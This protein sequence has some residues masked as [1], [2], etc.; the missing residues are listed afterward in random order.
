ML[1]E[2]R[3]KGNSLHPLIAGAV[4]GVL[5]LGWL[6]GCAANARPPTA[7]ATVGPSPLPSVRP[8]LDST[9]QPVSTGGAGSASTVGVIQLTWW[10]PDFMA[11]SAN[12]GGPLLAKF[13]KD[14]EKAQGGKVRVVPVVKASH[15]R[16]GLL[17]LMLAAQPVAPDVLPDLVALDTEDV[18]PA[19]AAGLLQ[20]LDGLV[21]PAALNGFYPFAK[22]AGSFNGHYL[23]APFIADVEHVIYNRAHLPTPPATWAD[24]RPGTVTYLFP[25]GVSQQPTDASTSEIVQST[26]VS[27]YLS[28]G[29]AID[30]G[31][32]QLV[33]DETPLERVLTFYSEARAL[34]VLPANAAQMGSLDDSFMAYADNAV[35][36]ADVSARSYLAGRDKLKDTDFA[37]Q[38]GW[39]GAAVPVASGW[40]LGILT[41]DPA[42][43]RAAADW[44]AWLLAPDRLGAWSQAA[45]WL[46]AKPAAWSAWGNSNYYGFLQSEL[47]AAVPE[48]AGLSDPQQAAQLDKAVLAV[49][50]NNADPADAARAV[51]TPQPTQ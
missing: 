49:L 29:G 1:P 7:T 40:A 41:N 10:M 47:A 19:A 24:L 43:Q 11:P 51:M 4:A 6:A 26:F 34:G 16:G 48:P 15:G 13:I 27:Q 2:R 35:L 44:I 42:R 45:G 22:Q 21:D 3:S 38:P 14:F 37:R 32:R 9:A 30:Q 23:A 46:P 20:P 31:T 5:L 33:L 39:N 50:N 17:D 25:A 28:A 12:D 8:Q 36:M 18:G